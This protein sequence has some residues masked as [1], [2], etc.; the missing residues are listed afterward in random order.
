[1]ALLKLQQIKETEE[2]A[3]NIRQDGQDESARILAAARN[4]A[5]A[6]INKANSKAERLYDTA[7]IKANEEVAEDYEKIMHNAIWECDILSE[8]AKKHHEE[9]VSLIVKRVMGTWRS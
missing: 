1:M 9:A 8:S 6:L 5:E 4:E 2:Q 3:K 7:R